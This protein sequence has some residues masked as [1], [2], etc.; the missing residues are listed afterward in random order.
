MFVIYFVQQM[1]SATIWNHNNE[2]GPSE[3][4]YKDKRQSK[5]KKKKH[6]TY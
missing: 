5:L 2:T 6:K 1:I 3:V 4:M